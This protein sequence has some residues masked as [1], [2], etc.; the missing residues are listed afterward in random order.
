MAY[1][2]LT[3]ATGLLGQY[4]LRDLTL[5]DIPL[6]VVV[7][8]SRHETAAQRIETIM[9]RQEQELGRSILRPLIFEGDLTQPHLGLSDRQIS[10]LRDHCEA[11]L[12]SAASLTFYS[13][14]ST[15]EPFLSNVTGT[16]NVLELC[17]SADIRQ[18]HHVST[19]YVCGQRRETIYES[20][21][22]VGQLPSND[23]ERT[24]LLAEELVRSADH[25]EQLTVHRPSIIVGD[26][27]TG[28]TCSFH[29]FYTPLRL[30]HALLSSLP[31][32]ALE[33]G[34]FLGELNMEGDE[35]KNLVPVDWV[36]K[37]MTWLITHSEYAGRTYHLTNPKPVTSVSMLIAIAQALEEMVNA[38]ESHKHAREIKQ[39]DL[40]A[41]NESFREQM[42]VYRSYWRDDPDFDVTNTQS[43]A[44]HLPCPELSHETML[45]LAQF[46]IKARFGWPREHSSPLDETIEGWLGTYLE[47][48]PHEHHLNGN[49]IHL[50]VAISGQGG[51]QWCFTLKN[52]SVVSAVQ[53]L[54][55]QLG[56]RCQLAA[57]TF[58]EVVTGETPFKQAIRDGK[59]LVEGTPS[60]RN[61]TERLFA[62]LAGG[63][64]NKSHQITQLG[65][66]K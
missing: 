33:Q 47:K 59:I 25:I 31:W 44:A 26:A 5:A 6:V 11:V 46:A 14:D 12:H 41:M 16:K 34:E 66:E 21:V 50:N 20:E 55:G 28:F 15:G 7:R 2:L 22:N 51:G 9:Q 27:K 8:R 65:V 4:L 38:E 53:G 40:K 19:A 64:N 3:G 18:L 30:A 17:R 48:G 36:S 56:N 29:G 52:G 63:L 13:N 49:G 35:R 61:H 39:S 32:S 42:E 1:T 43:A 37:V 62:C 24:K 54:H 60:E 57:K 23:Y 58:I 45:M 10:W